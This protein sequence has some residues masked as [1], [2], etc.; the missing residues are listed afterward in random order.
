M[1]GFLKNTEHKVFPIYITTNGQRVYEPEFLNP[2]QVNNLITQDSSS[3]QFT[4][5]FS[6]TGKLYA[7][8]KKQGLRGKKTDL[9]LDLLFLM[10]HGKNGE[11]GAAQGICQMLNIPFVSPTTLSSAI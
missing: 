1:Q 5:D 9:T 8:Q 4:I 10:L 7:T 3:T 6:K 11:D 2:K